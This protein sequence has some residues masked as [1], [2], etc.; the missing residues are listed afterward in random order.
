MRKTMRIVP[1]E[2]RMRRG[3]GETDVSRGAQIAIVFVART[4]SARYRR[5]VRVIAIEFSAVSI[6]RILSA[7]KFLILS[8]IAFEEI[9]LLEFRADRLCRSSANPRTGTYE[10]HDPKR[11]REFLMSRASVSR[12]PRSSGPFCGKNL[13]EY[14]APCANLV[15]SADGYV[16]AALSRAKG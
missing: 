11:T 9:E 10:S 6:S 7:K 5:S 1:D 13:D 12:A 16:P 2:K 3:D 4:S 8:K 15:F 14:R